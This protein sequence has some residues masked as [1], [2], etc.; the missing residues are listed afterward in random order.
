[1]IGGASA[2]KSGKKS[3]NTDRGCSE[4]GQKHFGVGRSALHT[5]QSVMQHCML[6][7]TAH[8]TQYA[9]N[10]SSHLFPRFAVSSRGHLYHDALSIL[11]THTHTHT[12][13]YMHTYT[14]KHT[15]THTH[16]HTHIHIRTHTCTHTHTHERARACTHTHNTHTN[17]HTKT[18]TQKH[19]HTHTHI[20]IHMR[21]NKPTCCGNIPNF[22]K[23]TDNSNEK[24]GFSQC[25]S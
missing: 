16:T 23:S 6:H 5:L 7:Q 1:M 12:R 18:H 13:T 10:L 25:D 14:H 19:T 3:E 2:K 9:Y 17:T 4:Y 8:F 15:H 24:V 22:I 20:H 21:F 11:H